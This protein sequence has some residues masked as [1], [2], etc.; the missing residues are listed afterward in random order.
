MNSAAVLRD[1]FGKYPSWKEIA[2]DKTFSRPVNPGYPGST[3]DRP[4]G[5][6][7]RLY[8]P[9][10]KG[11]LWGEAKNITM[12]LLKTDVFDRRYFR[13]DPVTLKEVMEGAYSEA[14]RYYDDMPR[15]GLTR[16]KYGTL[17]PGGGRIDRQ[18]W[19][20][21]YPFPCQKAVGQIIVRAED[22]A[23]ALQPEAVVSMADGSARVDMQKDSGEK[24]S[25]EWAIGMKRNIIAVKA[26]C[27]DLKIPLS[28][29]LYRHQDQ[30]H[31][32]YM[33]EKGNYIPKEKRAVVY[34][35][36]DPKEPVGYYDYEADAS[37]NGLFEPPVSGCDGRFF[38]IEQRFPAE[39]TFPGGFRY[40][41]M[42]LVSDPAARIS[43][44]G[45]EKYL[46][47]PQKMPRDAQGNLILPVRSVGHDDLYYN[48]ERAFSYVREAPGVAGT[49][50]LP[51]AGTGGAEFYVTVV[52]L[53]ESEHYLEDAKKALLEAEK[54]GYEG[55][56][57]ENQDWYD[58]LY[59]SRE[60]GRV[61]VEG[62]KQQEADEK[63]FNDVFLSWSYHHGG[64]CRPDPGRNEGSAGYAAFDVDTQ[65]W[66]SLPCYN[67][68]FTEGPWFVRNRPEVMLQ[69]PRLV[70]RWREALK[71]KAK[72]I[73]DLPG[74]IMGHGYLPPVLPDPCYIENQSLDFCMEVPGQVMKVIW[75]LWDYTGDEQYLRETAYPLLRELAIFYAAFARRGWD[76]QYYHLEPTVETES[77]GLSYRN[78]FAKDTTAAITMFRYILSTAAEAAE[79]LGAD[80]DLVPLW[81]EVAARLPPY[82]VFQMGMGPIL[83][84]NPGIIPRWS[85]GDHEINSA[86][87]PATLADEITLDSP[88]EQ[89]ELII[90]TADTV[91]NN[92]NTEAYIL[93][94]AFAD[95]TVAGY[96]KSPVKIDDALS[97]CE[98]ILAAPERLLNSRSGRIHLFPVTP[99]NAKAAFRNC[100]A[101][102]GFEVSAAKD[103]TGVL[104]VSVRA[105]RSIRCRIMNPWPGKALAVEGP[106]GKV[107]FSLDTSNG[108]CVEFEARA[109]NEYFLNLRE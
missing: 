75:N 65:A 96:N 62:A 35:P 80:G 7:L 74:L 77:Y 98:E 60:N 8:S 31:R 49:A 52:T 34:Y 91:R 47:T 46:G 88:R 84:G 82:P 44:Q 28:F 63:L 11:A 64:Y 45:L 106:E 89:R 2:R 40:V 100:L 87:Y 39:R 76:G 32:R 50:E 13:T 41:M 81:R 15:I 43:C 14:N 51:R 12:S 56:R 90:R 61:F 53:N 71:E 36:V 21:N 69:W 26:S 85:A 105:R 58:A 72:I 18:A 22:M 67:E 103:Q 55:L 42:G 30:G 68:L 107:S 25:L 93:A 97:L 10:I 19:S 73:Y 54:L 108:E 59:D 79:F 66:H 99:R 83:A 16:P 24:L 29:R 23:A 4:M 70:W 9:A 104:G 102:G 92:H 57:Q 5:P 27:R 6:N 3:F 101:R 1:I 86:N 38:W 94:G 37:F 33:D 20:E 48:L 78:E 109:G 95:Y 17:L